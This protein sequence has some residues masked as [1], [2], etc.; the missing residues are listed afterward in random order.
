LKQALKCRGPAMLLILLALPFCF[1]P[2]P[3]LSIPFGIAICLI[4]GCLV[5]GREPCLP[6]FIMRRRLS[7]TR[8]TQLLT[9]AVNIARQLE[10]FVRP[11]LA[12]LHTGPGMLQLIGLAIVIAWA[13]VLLAIGMM[14]KDGL[15]VLLGH[16]TVIVA[17]VFIALTSLF[18]V[19]GFHKLLDFF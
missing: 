6:R 12:F 19:R 4:G 7:P 14:E 8:L 13:V 3:G 17:W 16:L 1:F 2:I 9:G 11:R 10:K 15:C 5:I 18:A